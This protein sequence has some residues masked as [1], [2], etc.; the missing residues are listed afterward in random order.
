M[1]SIF[2]NLSHRVFDV[3][4]STAVRIRL[5]LVA[6]LLHCMVASVTG[7]VPRELSVH[8]ERESFILSQ[9]VL[10]VHSVLLVEC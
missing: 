3:E 10:R 6:N 4:V 9:L 8:G 7:K 2:S 1:C 5:Q